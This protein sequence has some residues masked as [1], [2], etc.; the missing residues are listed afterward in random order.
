[1]ELANHLET[2]FYLLFFFVFVK[3]KFASSIVDALDICDSIITNFEF[4]NK[5]VK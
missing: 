3:V 2:L 4:E 1:M 5:K